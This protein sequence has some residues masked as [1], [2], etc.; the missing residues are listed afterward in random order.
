[1]SSTELCAGLIALWLRW[2]PGIIAVAQDRSDRPVDAIQGIVAALIRRHTLRV[3]QQRAYAF[4]DNAIRRNQL[5]P[6]LLIQ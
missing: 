5:V 4:W 3:A 1:M 2:A 6:F